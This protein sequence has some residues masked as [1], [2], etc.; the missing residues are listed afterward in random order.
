VR[1][2]SETAHFETGVVFT[3]SGFATGA[4]VA[5]VPLLFKN[6]NDW[7]SGAQ[8]VNVSQVPVVVN[9]SMLQRD[10]PITLGLGP[11]T[12]APNESFTYYLPAIQEL[13][14]G[15]VGSGVFTAS[16]PIAV[17][18]Q[19]LNSARGAGM[20]YTG[21]SG[22]TPNV[23]VPVVFKGSAGWDSG[24]Q[25]QN[26]GQGDALVDI[27]Y[28][29][30]G[31]VTVADRALIAAGSSTTFYQEEH[32]G[33]PPGIIGAAQVTSVGGAPIVAIVNEVNYERSGDASMSYE[34]VN[35]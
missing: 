23:S 26:L 2:A 10:A 5:N 32:P 14:E 19:Q 7:V 15:F 18:V 31:G 35:Y 21:F 3:Y 16:G 8:V 20:A 13:P 4:N 22:G 27:T 12:L 29:L 6:Y 25:V 11:R 17:V 24:V 30:P 34:G 33:L 1:V 9:A 28:H